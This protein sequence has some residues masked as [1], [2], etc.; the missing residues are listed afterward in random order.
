MEKSKPVI[1]N[2][3]SYEKAAL[4][5]NIAQVVKISAKRKISLFSEKN[6]YISIYSC[7]FICQIQTDIE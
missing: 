3:I 1:L 5:I 7:I 6:D 2:E 4:L